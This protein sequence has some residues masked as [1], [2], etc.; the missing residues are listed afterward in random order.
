MM[1]LALSV[2]LLATQAPPPPTSAP[3]SAPAT[4]PMEAP[5]ARLETLLTGL[6]GKPQTALSVKLGPPDSER[7]ASDGKVLFWSV[8][9]QGATVCG[10]TAG[11]GL[12]CGRQGDAECL[13]AAAFDQAGGLKVWRTSGTLAACEKAADQIEAAAPKTKTGG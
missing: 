8:R 12:S 13:V 9:I 5:S 11:G 4:G 3:A 7:V 1:M 10:A 6:K 2:M